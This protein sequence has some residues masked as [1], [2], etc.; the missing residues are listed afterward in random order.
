MVSDTAASDWTHRLPP[1][2]FTDVAV[3]AYA[4]WTVAANLVVVA[5]GTARALGLAALAAL[6]LLLLLLAVGLRAR[7]WRV[8]YLDDLRDD[9]MLPSRVPA[10]GALVAMLAA[11]AASLLGWVVTHNPWVAWLGFTL[12]AAVAAS[13]ALRE[14]FPPADQGERVSARLEPRRGERAALYLLALAC[15]AFTLLAVRP[16]ADDTFYLSMAQS[17]I[18]YPGQALLRITNLHG[19]VTALLGPQPLYPP[20]RVHS[21]ELLGGLIGKWSGLEPAAVIHFGFATALSWLAPFALARLMRLLAPRRWLLGVTAAVAFYMID[22]SASRGFANHAF[23]RMFDGKAA[24]LTVGVP[25]ICAYGLRAGAR[26]SARRVLM[27]ALAQI[28]ALG[29][30]S[31]GLWLAP[32]LA[33]VSVVAATP[34]WRSLPRRLGASLLSSAYV[35]AIG[36]WVLGAMG[37]GASAVSSDV[38]IASD[39]PELAL[40]ARTAGPQLSPRFAAI[41]EA[42]PAVLGPE[43]TAIGLLAIA[44]LACPLAPN[45]LGS[46]WFSLLALLAGGVFGNPLLADVMAQHVVGTATYERIFWLL[47]V[48]VGLG[49]CCVTLYSW[50]RRRLPAPLAGLLVAC[51]LLGFFGATTTR[52]VISKENRSKLAFPPKL[53]LP[54]H[55][56]RIARV[57]CTLAPRGKYALAAQSVLQQLPILHRCAYPLMTFDRWMVAPAGDKLARDDLVH[58]VSRPDDVPL[59]RAAWFVGALERYHPD[60]I[61]LAREARDNRN[62]RSL[63]RLAG[64]ERVDHVEGDD[65]FA[66]TSGRSSRQYQRVARALCDLVGAGGS[67]VVVAPFGVAAVLEPLGCSTVL[68]APSQVIGASQPQLR[69]LLLLERAAFVG[70]RDSRLDLRQLASLLRQREATALVLTRAAR[71]DHALT[72]LLWQ[73]DFRSARAL[74]DDKIYLRRAPAP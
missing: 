29:L 41:G 68:T 65:V 27:L 14:P 69:D 61:V 40:P 8:A 30:S 44:L 15:A 66:R 48:A 54:P 49:V 52:M 19:P 2:A 57:I 13:F 59:S 73:L 4:L 16:R 11:P 60:V 31:T 47:P 24:L 34:A 71:R 64:Y 5:G 3:L 72:K 37:A 46:R 17:V 33:M 12:S 20:Y 39:A 7:A 26:P 56:Q 38:D 28:A 67:A 43:R 32:T 36:L 21:F 6:L 25:L 50:S 45:V 74:A 23:V 22:G 53:K 9:P 70:S 62:T 55:A 63:I 10:R 35:I 51:V 42:V 18:D 1:G 58:Y